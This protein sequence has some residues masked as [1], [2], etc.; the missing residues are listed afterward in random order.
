MRRGH[1]TWDVNVKLQIRRTL[2]VSDNWLYTWPQREEVAGGDRAEWS[3]LMA[4]RYNGGPSQQSH[5]RAEWSWLVASRANGYTKYACLPAALSAGE[6]W[7][8]SVGDSTPMRGLPVVGGK[9]KFIIRLVAGLGNWMN[10]YRLISRWENCYTV[11]PD[12][13][14]WSVSFRSDGITVRVGML[15]KLGETCHS[16]N[17]RQVTCTRLVTIHQSVKIKSNRLWGP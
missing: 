12:G 5:D 10:W 9:L 8:T 15:W 7:V 16:D 17:C 13:L 6:R 14:D 1:V 3:W 11:R 4:T 2:N